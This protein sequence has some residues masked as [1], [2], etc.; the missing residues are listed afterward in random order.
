[1]AQGTMGNSENYTVT[2][3]ASWG[4]SSQC[5]QDTRMAMTRTLQIANSKQGFLKELQNNL[6]WFFKLG[7]VPAPCC[8]WW[9]VSLHVPFGVTEP[10]PLKPEEGCDTPQVP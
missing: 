8:W 5:T 9:R 7:K 1:M 3:S 4:R 2:A 10:L 6:C